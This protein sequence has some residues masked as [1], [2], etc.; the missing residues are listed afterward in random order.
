MGRLVFTV[1]SDEALYN[2]SMIGNGE[3]ATLLGP[4]DTQR[5]MP[6]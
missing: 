5:A 3:L 1:I 2:S 6:A 4:G